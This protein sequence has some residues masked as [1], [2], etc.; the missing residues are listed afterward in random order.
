MVKDIKRALMIAKGVS[1]P[2][3]AYHGTPYDFDRFDFSKIG[4]G[5]GAQAYGH[6]LYFAG[7]EPVAKGYRDKLAKDWFVTPNG[8]FWTPDSLEHLN[9]RVRARNHAPYLDRAI[10]Y[11]QGILSDK[12][13]SGEMQAKAKRDLD[14]LI[15][16]QK[17]GGV[18]PVT[19]RMYEVA[20][21][22]DPEKFLDWDRPLRDQRHI[23]EMAA[24]S[25]GGERAA[26]QAW[27]D[28]DALNDHLSGI[29]YDE[30]HPLW[31][32]YN[33]LSAPGADR[34]RIKIGGLYDALDREA[35]NPEK[36]PANRQLTQ[37]GEDLY[38]AVSQMGKTN[39]LGSQA[40]ETRGVPGVRYFDALSR[41]AGEGTSNYVVFPTPEDILE[42]TRKYARGGTADHPLTQDVYHGTTQNIPEFR[43][44]ADDYAL[45]YGLGVHVARDPKVAS[46]EYFTNRNNTGEGGNMMPLKTLTDDKFYPVEQRLLP[47]LPPDTPKTSRTVR[48]DDR[49]V[50]EAIM[51]HALKRDP[52][53]MK[54]VLMEQRALPEEEAADAVKKLRSGEP[55]QHYDQTYNNIDELVEDHLLSPWNP[56]DRAWA[57]RSFRDDL[58]KK[59]YAGVKYINTSPNETAGA[60]DPTCYIV[61][62]KP[63]SE[64]Y[65]PLRGRFAAFNPEDKASPDL[66]K[67]EGGAVDEA[68]K[69][70]GYWQD[71]PAV[72]RGAHDWLEGKQREAASDPKLLRGAT[73]GGTGV[74]NIPVDMLK[75]VPGAMD[76]KPFPGRPKYDRLMKT[77]KTEGWKPTPILVGVNHK[78]KPYI[79]EGNH[80][81][82]VARALGQTHV[83][84]EIKWWN[85][86]EEVEGDWHPRKIA[87]KLMKY[88]REPRAVGGR[89]KDE[90]RALMIARK[91]HALL[92]RVANIYPGPRGGMDPSPGGGGY[93]GPGGGKY[94]GPSNYADG[95]GVDDYGGSH[96]PPS[97]ENGAPLHDLTGGG[98]VY[99]DDVYGPRAVQYY[100]TGD[101]GMDAHTFNIA[102]QV[103]GK[104]AA[105]VTIYRAV[106]HTPSTS[107]QLATLKRQMAEHMRRGKVPEGEDPKGWYDRAHAERARLSAMP[108][109]AESR[110]GINHG[111]W[112]TTNPAYAR[113]HGE[114]ALRGKYK[115][116]RKTVRAD[117][118]YT[119]GDSIHEYGYWP[120]DKRA[121][122][123]KIPPFK[124]HSGAAKLIE[125]KGQAKATPQQYAAMPG[126][127]PDELKH[128]KFE[129][130]GNKALPK[131]QVLEHLEGNT[132]PLQETV[133]T[134]KDERSAL[135]RYSSPSQSLALPGGANYREV[136]LKLPLH[137]AAQEAK[138]RAQELN[139]AWNARK[140][141]KQEFLDTR[142]RQ[143][144]E[145]AADAHKRYEDAIKTYE[146]AMW[147]HMRATAKAAET[148]FQSDHWP[149]EPNVVAH[150]RMH[151]R[152][153][154]N[155]EKVLHVEELQSDWG[156][157][158]REKGFKTAPLTPNERDEFNQLN[159]LPDKVRTPEQT[160]RLYEL[161]AKSNG[162]PPG[163]YVDNTQ[164]WTDLAL[165]RVLHEAAHGGYD[166]VVFTPGE[167]QNKR[168]SL[169]KHLS[170]VHYHPESNTLNADDL[171]GFRVVSKH[172]TPEELPETV[173]KELAQRLLE[174]KPDSLGV[175]SLS[176][177]DLKVGGA[178]MRGYY[179]NIL[180]KRLQA[181]A[182]QHDPQAKVQLHGHSLSSSLRVM[183]ED[184]LGRFGVMNGNNFQGSF[185]SEN[186]AQE[187]VA[188][189]KE[190]DTPLHSLDVTPQMRESIKQNGFNQFK[191]GGDVTVAKKPS[192]PAI[193]KSLDLRS[194]ETFPEL[195]TRYPKTAP[196]EWAVDPSSKKDYLAKRLSP[197][198]IAVQTAKKIIQK[199]IEEGRYKPYFDPLKRF[200]A[201]S[202]EFGKKVDTTTIRKV[203]P[204]TQAK[205]EGKARS[206]EATSRLMTAFE[207]GMLQAR[208]AGDWYLMG[209]L[210]NEYVA[211]YGPKVG[212]Q[213][214]KE[215][216]A[217]AMAATTGGADPTANFLTAH[218]GNYVKKHKQGFP[219]NTYDLPYPIGGRFI[220]GNIDQYN[221]MITQGKGVT[222][223]NPKRYNFSHNFLGDPTGATI[224]EQ[225]SG[226]YEPGLKVP[227]EGTYGHY[228]GA[229]ADLA[230][231]AKGAKS[232]RHFQEVAWA[233]AK[234]MG[235]KGGYK[236]SPMI[237]HINQSI[238][239]T[240]RITGMSP[241]EVV[242]KNLVDVQGPMFKK[243]GRAG[244]ADGGGIDRLLQSLR[245]SFSQLN[246]QPAPAATDYSQM[247]GQATGQVPDAA[248]QQMLTQAL[249]G[250][251]W[252]DLFPT[253]AY[254]PP[255][256]P[257][258][259]PAAPAAVEQPAQPAY[260]P[261]WSMTSGMDANVSAPGRKR[262]GAAGQKRKST[263]QSDIVERAL[264]ATRRK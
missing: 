204:E 239:R 167:E 12:Y 104:P 87:P 126:I 247:M 112:V 71:N 227:P 65:Y 79:L 4:A 166:K 34:A 141:A 168:Y 176:G 262:G 77:V 55:W 117:E 144:P 160:Q 202:P 232:P 18:S 163:P 28:W 100:G 39:A 259:A 62:N 214:F 180:P 61:F 51:K 29:D 248:Y 97:P 253:A 211:K 14:K 244:Y 245:G 59:G 95:G 11:A 88:E 101:A 179:D 73:T 134:G 178:G 137:A 96:R 250:K 38:R 238:E 140:A 223:A 9:V 113:Q 171:Y 172:S 114:S 169:E 189:K 203:R 158:G 174:T 107:E 184:P 7:H 109:S 50:G 156:Q 16:L 41:G 30:G 48:S 251:S 213:L 42:I 46:S 128:S 37:K 76:E 136:L 181:L 200:D 210:H 246:Q 249:G 93:A 17:Q 67:A 149:E 75:N 139:E 74:V 225:M 23:L 230:K 52:A 81:A 175:H 103:R 252:S 205:Y 122:G 35:A 229:L 78:G 102:R 123:G 190:N 228:E 151:D 219:E 83:P 5:E 138:K 222:P 215:R 264:A 70:A 111:D 86:G 69:N 258:A 241:E 89:T 196:P 224:D 206:K 240:A 207:R 1:A 119:N 3:R 110:Y 218:Y 194:T 150:I 58:I 13:S 147:R 115:I 43:D 256:A 116:I 162:I 129:A 231:T 21:H 92:A 56:E 44:R 60:D 32:R 54:R 120:R 187:F 157:Q 127:K 260:G 193:K 131:E 124:L 234:D 209:Q 155:G 146:T 254:K 47:Y 15:E 226:L 64:G 118:L 85:G 220:A 201:S 121:D 165:K 183:P 98:N 217:D 173:G 19:G 142:D 6:G 212:S 33:Q 94:I 135:R 197:E 185:G 10:E 199:D 182:Q 80:R 82:A 255:A 161:Y 20:I 192:A 177:L 152:K 148:G 170:A 31:K 237:S 108:A 68:L 2:I 84:G 221:K 159:V 57:V 27:K 188:F 145:E 133:Y 243:G 91:Q 99:P 72:S 22:A 26:R 186:E 53:L 143:G 8:K 45:S 233:G 195:A 40:L 132:V 106:P 164:K 236:A 125:A 235:T 261:N 36:Y 191:R 242:A 66:M 24:E 216:F 154:P 49:A 263:V 153:G 208:D 90:R 25:V 105:K 130:L 198:A 257:A 63:T